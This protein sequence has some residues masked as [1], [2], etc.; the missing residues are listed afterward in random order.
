MPHNR[1]TNSVH[2]EE[3]ARLARQEK[4]LVVIE[5][6]LRNLDPEPMA[7][8]PTDTAKERRSSRLEQKRRHKPKRNNSSSGSTSQ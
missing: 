1:Y 2:K 6:S 4:E 8:A 7:G 5:K 3:R